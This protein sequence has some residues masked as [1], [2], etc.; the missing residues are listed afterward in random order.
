[1][2]RG[3]HMLIS[4][5]RTKDVL[6]LQRS[7]ETQTWEGPVGLSSLL[8]THFLMANLELLG[9]F[10]SVMSML[11][12]VPCQCVVSDWPALC[13]KHTVQNAP[14]Q[15]VLPSVTSK[16]GFYGVLPFI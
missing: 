15:P 16:L 6:G 4:S 14:G 8:L 11:G 12:Q 5:T 9:L 13:Q 10:S 2:H 1:M 7:V 3:S